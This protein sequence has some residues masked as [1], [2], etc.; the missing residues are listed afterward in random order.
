MVIQ[1][2]IA[3]MNANRQ[4]NITTNLQA[5]SSEK[6]SSGYKIN[7]A[8]DD[9]AGLAISEKM[10]RQI[11]GL[12]QGIKNVQD[13]ISM[14]QIGDGALE[15]VM[16]MAHRMTELSVKAS[17]DTLTDEDRK[18]IQSEIDA[19]LTEVERI[20]EVTEF[21]NIRIFGKGEEIIYNSDGTPLIEGSIPYSSFSFAD[22]NISQNPVFS[23]LSN[24]DYLALSASVN[25][26]NSA[27]NGNSYNLIYGDGSTSNTS[28]RISYESNGNTVTQ[29]LKLDSDFTIT[30]Y[31]N[32]NGRV[33]RDLIYDKDGVSFTITETATPNSANKYYQMDYSIKNTGTTE[34]DLEF[35]FHADTAYNNNDICES[36]YIGGSLVDSTRIYKSTDYSGVESNSNVFDGVPSSLSIVNKDEA[37][38]FS[39]KIDFTT[40]PDML[41]IGHYSSIDDWSYYDSTSSLGRSTTNMDLGFSALWQKNDMASGQTMSVSFN[42]GIAATESDSNLNQSE[43]KM[44][45]KPAVIVTDAKEFWIQ[46]SSNVDDGMYISFGQID[47]DALN[48]RDLDVTKSDRARQSIERVKKAQNHVSELRSHIGAQTNRLEHTARNQANTMENTQSAESLIRDTDMAAEMVKYSNN[49]ILAQA[50]QAM[51]AQAN[52][53]N[54]GVLSLLQ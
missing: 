26:A 29:E 44:S 42:Y 31:S 22:V 27:A 38:A 10:R 13:G 33:S 9:A 4:L 54:Q 30:N 51:L 6:L 35:M 47:L 15:E 49:N 24:G 16:V 50:G 5:K 39:E 18:Y 2:N 41:S 3:G 34:L 8:A 37:L 25:D 48:L 17:N 32:N 40:R 53:T 21:N 1:H 20:D 12:D 45:N 11:R 19:I 14:C 43:I 52:Q 46:A 7:R 28:V 23:A 36:Y